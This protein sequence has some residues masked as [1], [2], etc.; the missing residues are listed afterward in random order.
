VSYLYYADRV[1]QLPLGVIGVAIGVV[2]LPEMARKLRSGDEAGAVA[3]QNR[4][5][6]FALF[7]T[8]PATVALIALP[9][10]IVNTCFEHGVFTR[11]D[12]LATA[13]ALAAFAIG[14]PAFTMN[15]IFSP[16]FF[17][18]EDTRRPMMFAITSVVINVTGSLILSSF[19]G[20]V[21]IALSTALAAW[22]N[23][24]LLGMT[25]ARNG[26]YAP[27]ARLKSKLPRIIGAS[28]G[29]GVILLVCF[30]VVQPVFEGGHALWVRALVLC[31]L[32]AIGT[33]SYFGLAHVLGAMKFSELR[34]M[35]RGRG[36]T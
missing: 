27:D 7:L 34:S 4:A 28:L 24:S 22:V 33:I 15:K 19:I 8:L 1:Y 14:L 6:E 35:L 16:G 30:L 3:N 12:T 9:L 11:S 13:S 2:L 17:A 31:A 26:H 29:M 25:L 5:L 32:V 23:S 18:R 10:A 20:H 36:F 21:G